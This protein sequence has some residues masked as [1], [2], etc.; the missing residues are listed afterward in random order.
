[1]AGRDYGRHLGYDDSWDTTAPRRGARDRWETRSDVLP[2]PRPG[3][4]DDETI[5]VRRSGWN[6]D[7]REDDDTLRSRWHGFNERLGADTGYDPLDPRGYYAAPPW[8]S[9]EAR[10][11]GNEWEREPRWRTVSYDPYEDWRPRRGRGRRRWGR[12]VGRGPA[13]WRE[14]EWERSRGDA[15]APW[16]NGARWQERSPGAS[17][18]GVHAGKGPRG[19]RRSD[20]RIH[21]EISD[22]LMAHADL[23]PSAVEVRVENGE[24]TLEGAVTDRSDK[25]LA[26]DLA[27]TVPG[28]QQVFNRLRVSG[29]EPAHTNR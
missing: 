22:R 17:E 2:D 24:V 26:E 15:F 7:W 5:P 25:R 11:T 13:S 4:A 23:D 10:A 9:G 6:N 27:Y 18:R 16:N 8:R 3:W 19:Y 1:M 29:A 21:E 14:Q 28:V 12:W 20:T